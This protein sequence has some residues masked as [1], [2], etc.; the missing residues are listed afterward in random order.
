VLYTTVGAAVLAGFVGTDVLTSVAG[1]GVLVTA[2]GA[3]EQLAAIMGIK[4]NEIALKSVYF[5]I[6][7]IFS[8]IGRIYNRLIT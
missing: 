8:I 7:L 6:F 3:G 5:I 2:M 1:I 4:I